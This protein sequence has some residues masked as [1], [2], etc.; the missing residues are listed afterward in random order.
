MGNPVPTNRSVWEI[1][2][3]LNALGAKLPVTKTYDTVTKTV[4][5]MLANGQ[6]L[7]P[8]FARV[9]DTVV[10]VD[11]NTYD[12]VADQYAIMKSPKPQPV[13]GDNFI[14][15]NNALVSMGRAGDLGKQKDALGFS[16]AAKFKKL[17]EDW[18]KVAESPA[19]RSLMLAVPPVW[20]QF[21]TTN[22]MNYQD[23]YNAAPLVTRV[24]MPHPAAL[25]PGGIGE[26]F[27]D[28]W[29]PALAIASDSA[30]QVLQQAG[31]S[32]AQGAAKVK[33]EEIFSWGWTLAGVGMLGGLAY[34][35]TRNRRTSAM[36]GLDAG[37]P[38]A[39]TSRDA[40]RPPSRKG[41]D[42]IERL[43]YGYGAAP[44]KTRRFKPG[45]K[46]VFGRRY[47]EQTRGTVIAV[48]P[49]T[50]RIRQE[51]GRGV[52]RIRGAGT[53]WRVSPDFVSLA[54]LHSR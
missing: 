17:T 43:P 26:A 28:L 35:V 51:E 9:S 48:N 30:K 12:L 14:S 45:D 18:A 15:L 42:P 46:V 11:K 29:N 44:S 31:V 38:W 20:S 22:W 41:D 25:E 24:K 23:I 34:W 6:K 39:K 4:W 21:L 33:E 8:L 16:N 54:G 47:G 53:V 1:Q 2:T 52:T 5:E 3:L 50:I 37:Y 49:K 40:A 19:R 13:K 27:R 10:A 32:F 36:H 7:A